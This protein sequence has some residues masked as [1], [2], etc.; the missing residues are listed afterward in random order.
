[1]T[2]ARASAWA[3]LLERSVG[4]RKFVIIDIQRLASRAGAIPVHVHCGVFDDAPRQASVAGEE[5][6]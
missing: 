2:L 1:M 6:R 4:K 5:K 3:A